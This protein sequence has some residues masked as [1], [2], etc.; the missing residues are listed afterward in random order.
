[1]KKH[2]TRGPGGANHPKKIR[3][4]IV[5]DEL[6][7]SSMLEE[8]L[9]RFRDLTVVG[10]APDGE[11]GWE[12]CQTTQPDLA[13]VDIELPKVDGLKLIQRLA[14]EY[15]RMRLLSMSGL[16]DAYTIWSVL[17]CGAHGYVDKTQAPELLVEAVRAV[18]RGN[19]FFGPTFSQVRQEWLARPEA[20]QKILSE[21]EQ[22]VLRGVVAGWD[23]ARIGVELGISPATIEVHRKR[24]RQKVGVHNDRGL[25]FYAR[26]WGLDTRIQRGN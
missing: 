25:L 6:L 3:I 8:L 16:M 21:R 2:T 17:Q 9:M 26:Q 13:L 19:T 10:R 22:Q 20:F 7:L 1:M 15:P 5:E 11:A 23:D 18:A 24:I 4:A 12:L 14:G